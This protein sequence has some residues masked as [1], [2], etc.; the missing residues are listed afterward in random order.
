MKKSKF[1]DFFIDKSQ[2]ATKNRYLCKE[3][4][5]PTLLAW[6]NKKNRMLFSA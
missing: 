4:S 5:P 1:P 6:K 2:T 3:K